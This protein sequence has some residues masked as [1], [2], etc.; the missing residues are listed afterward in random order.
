[1]LQVA[2]ATKN[3]VIVLGATSLDRRWQEAI[4]KAAEPLAGRIKFTYYNDLSFD[5]ML[6]RVSTLPPDSYIFFLLLLRDADGVTLKSDEALRQ[7]PS[8]RQRSHQLHL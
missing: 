7:A 1:M 6:E 2:P 5:Q 8:S 4:Q 3:I